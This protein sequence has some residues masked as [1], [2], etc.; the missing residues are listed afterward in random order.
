LEPEPKGGKCAYKRFIEERGI[1][2]PPASQLEKPPDATLSAADSSSSQFASIL[3]GELLP[4]APLID[5]ISVRFIR[6]YALKRLV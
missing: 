5:D 1:S 6:K 2:N 4:D 3:T